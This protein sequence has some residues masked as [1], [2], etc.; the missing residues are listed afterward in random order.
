MAAVMVF[1]MVFYFLLYIQSAVRC[2]KRCPVTDTTIKIQVLVF[3][4]VTPHNVAIGYQHF[5]GPCCLHLTI[6]KIV[7]V[8]AG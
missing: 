8:Q 3:R 5:G 6:F 1:F 7:S 4:D 2:T